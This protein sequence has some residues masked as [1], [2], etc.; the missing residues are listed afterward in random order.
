MRQDYKCPWCDGYHSWPYIAGLT[1]LIVFTIPVGIVIFLVHYSEYGYRRG[2]SYNP[3][4]DAHA[5]KMMGEEEE[6]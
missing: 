2:H 6:L 1:A 4:C 3:D 5:K